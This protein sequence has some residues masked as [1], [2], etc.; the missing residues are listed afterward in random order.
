MESMEKRVGV[1]GNTNR[2]NVTEASKEGQNPIYPVFSC[3]N[4]D[5]LYGSYNQ[6]QAYREAD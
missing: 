3:E 1:Q 2:H 5:A 4:K 6:K